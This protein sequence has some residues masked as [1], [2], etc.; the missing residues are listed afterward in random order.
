MHWS[1]LKLR[2]RALNKVKSHVPPSDQSHSS[3]VQIQ[4]SHPIQGETRTLS[5]LFK[6][7]RTTAALCDTD[8]GVLT[9]NSQTGTWRSVQMNREELCA[10]FSVVVVWDDISLKWLR[11]LGCGIKTKVVTAAVVSASKRSSVGDLLMKVSP[12]W[13]RHSGGLLTLRIDWRGSA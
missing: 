9:T 11:P 3:Y 8:E 2:L 4:S 10:P 12:L 13:R 1:L 6:S 7:S 5:C